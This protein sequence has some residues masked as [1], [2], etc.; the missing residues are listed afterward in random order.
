MRV[1]TTVFVGADLCVATM[2]CHLM[3]LETLP[4]INDLSSLSID[5]VEWSGD[6][7]AGL[8]QVVSLVNQPDKTRALDEV[9]LQISQLY[10]LLIK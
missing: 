5:H 7:V 10:H 2:A 8:C 4:A 9:C 6:L 3:V 1:V